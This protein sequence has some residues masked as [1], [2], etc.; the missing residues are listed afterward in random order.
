MGSAW[1]GSLSYIGLLLSYQKIAT[2][3]FDNLASFQKAGY[4]R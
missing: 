4:F 2:I 3:N 1:F